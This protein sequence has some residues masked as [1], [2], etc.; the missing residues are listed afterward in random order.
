MIERFDSKVEHVRWVH[1]SGEQPLIGL[2]EHDAI[3]EFGFAQRTH[4][5]ASFAVIEDQPLAFGYGLHDESDILA[6]SN[7]GAD[8]EPHA[9]QGSVVAGVLAR[10]IAR[11][12]FDGD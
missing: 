5:T 10:R 4:T 8:L 1:D 6:A 2:V 3:V 7:R 12:E 11:L 9:A